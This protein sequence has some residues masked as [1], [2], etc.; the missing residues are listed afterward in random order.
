[1]GLKKIRLM[2]WHKFLLLLTGSIAVLCLGLA[3]ANWWSFSQAGRQIELESKKILSKQTESFLTEIVRGQ[4]QALDLQLAQ[5]KATAVHGSIYLNRFMTENSPKEV[6]VDNSLRALQE[7]V[8][9]STM[10]YFINTKG[11]LWIYPALDPGLVLQPD[12]NLVRE[13]FFPSSYNFQNRNGEA[14]WSQVHANPLDIQYDTVVDAISPVLNNETIHGYVGISVSLARLIAQFNQRQPIRGSYTFL[15]NKG[16]QLMAASPN[17][18]VDLSPSS[19]SLTRGVIDLSNTGNSSLNTVLKNMAL[20]R[21]SLEKVVIK[22][23]VKYLAYQP[24]VNIDWSLGIVV[25]LPLVTVASAQMAKVVQTSSLRSLTWMI[26]WAGGL[27][28]V[29]CILGGILIKRLTS[30][31]REMVT[32]TEHIARGK[33]DHRV[34]IT[35]LDEIGALAKAFN[36]MTVQLSDAFN[37]LNHRIEELEQRV[38]KR[39]AQLE[40]VNKELEAFAYSVSHDLRSPLRGIDGFSQALLED[41]SESLDAQGKDYL[42]RVRVATQRMGRLID[43]LLSLSR[44]SRC[45]I[46]R[47]TVDLSEMAKEIMGE[48]QEREPERTVEVK[49]ADGLVANCDTYLLRIVLENLLDNAFKFS[50][51]RPKAL[52]ELGKIE[53][54]SESVIFVRDNG[55]GFDMTYADKL[56]GAFQRLHKATE[57]E[58]IGIGL[59]TVQR[60]IHRH[61]G[62][63][64]AEGAVNS[65]ATFYFTI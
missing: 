23:E 21:T 27:L 13:S 36:S 1:M 37:K 50:S 3:L 31:I 61:G 15:L 29:A 48:L 25:P 7:R 52:I 57:F 54:G 33:L 62:R 24:L 5:A 35:S 42:R 38:I 14:V 60:I 6:Q 41:Y 11:D 44:L 20:G 22:D 45:K 19:K 39:T 34:E 47:K 51:N 64:W 46:D 4:A 12:F 26:F 43:D 55:V 56:F 65:G 9:N 58:G 53:Q 8:D 63:I 59:A 16:L 49:I 32:V 40:T 10:A 17:A 18:R 2:L 28:S 30:P